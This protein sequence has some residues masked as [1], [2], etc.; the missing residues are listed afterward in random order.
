MQF[1]QPEA[2]RVTDDD[3]VGSGNIQ[4]RFDNRRAY[5][6]VRLMPDKRQH[7][8]LQFVFGHLPVPDD[9]PGLRNQLLQLV[10]HTQN[11]VYPVMQI[12]HL[13]LPRQLPQDRLPDPLPVIRTYLRHDAPP[14]QRR[15]RQRGNIPQPQQRHVQRPRDRRGRHRQQIHRRPHPLQPLLVLHPEPLLLID[16]HQPQ[17]L[18]PHIP[19]Q[20]P[21]RPDQ[22]IHLPAGRPVENLPGLPAGLEPADR[23][24]R[25]RIIR[26]P[27]RK[28]AVMLFR[29]HRRRHQ[30]SNLFAIFHR[31]EHRP[32][33]Q[34][35]LAVPHIPAQQPVHRA[36]QL[37]VPLDFLVRRPLVIR[38][39]VQKRFLK[40]L[41]PRRIV[42]KPDPRHTLP[43]GLNL[44]QFRGHILHR[45]PH[46]LLLLLPAFAAQPREHHPPRPA[47]HVLMHQVDLAGRHMHQRFA[48]I[49]QRQIF[50]LPAPLGQRLHP[51][52]P[53]DPVRYMHHQIVLF[54]IRK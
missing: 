29:Q 52:E 10:R 8:L 53:P 6:Y 12:I 38:L 36:A 21:V 22:H 13:A 2:V 44:Q 54:Q 11:I 28:R 43:L 23:L 9:N 5:Q 51:Q 34:L 14:V 24:H 49:F 46:L 47:S 37:H 41:L 27:L 25:K 50:F 39:L 3:G 33:R 45:L 19:T 31:L 35:R 15:R 18:K 7:F 16:N 32:D 48:G 1:R 42:R 30:H 4:P 20:N 26:Q 40:F 17:I